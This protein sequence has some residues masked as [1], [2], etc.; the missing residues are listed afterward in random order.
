M[1][2]TKAYKY[3]SIYKKKHFEEICF[4]DCINRNVLQIR[5][6]ALSYNMR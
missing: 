2:K 5:R 3:T 1:V 4:L 6:N